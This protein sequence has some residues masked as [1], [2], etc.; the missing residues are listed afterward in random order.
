MDPQ[1]CFQLWLD[2]TSGAR[3]SEIT[4]S[5]NAWIGKGGFRAVCKTPDGEGTVEYLYSSSA[6]VKIG[7][8]IR[9]FSFGS[10]K[11]SAQTS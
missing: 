5:Y 4:E 3:A 11:E 9:T 7:E 10:L 6:D 2:A 8:R 1:A